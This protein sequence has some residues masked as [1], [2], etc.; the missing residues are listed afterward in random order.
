MAQVGPAEAPAASRNIDR[1]RAVG[2]PRDG[3][4]RATPPTGRRGCGRAGVEKATANG[5]GSIWHL[6]AIVLV[7]LKQ[8]DQLAYVP[9]LADVLRGG[10]SLD[11]DTVFGEELDLP[12]GPR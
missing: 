10:E 5:S 6:L 7:Q 11:L 3:S 8:F 12:M 4:Q 1:P 2:R 9:Q